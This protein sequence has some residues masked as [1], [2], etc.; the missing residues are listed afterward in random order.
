MQRTSSR[1]PRAKSGGLISYQ[2]NFPDLF[3]H[4]AETWTRFLRGTKPKDIPVEQLDRFEL[5]INLETAEGIELKIPKSLLT[6]E[7]A[8]A[9]AAAVTAAATM[10]RHSAGRHC[11][12]AERRG[13]RD[14]NDCSTH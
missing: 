10:A 6:A 12:H 14:R 5:A 11:R 1:I 3:R 9:P 2:P 4:A 8:A 13:R 7:V